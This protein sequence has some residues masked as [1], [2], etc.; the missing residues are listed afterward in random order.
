MDPTPTGMLIAALIGLL[1]GV[2]TVVVLPLII[3]VQ[4]RR[5]KDYDL[6]V[7]K[8]DSLEKKDVAHDV[9][10]TALGGKLETIQLIHTELRE[11][12]ASMLSRTEFEQRI[13][14]MEREIRDSR[15]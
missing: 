13:A 9:A 1:G 6:L 14:S 10:L 5:D 3:Y 2:V 7:T 11:M 15:R 4:R 8:V 12:R